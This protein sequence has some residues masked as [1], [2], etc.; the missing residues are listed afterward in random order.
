[1]MT[2]RLGMLLPDIPIELKSN[3]TAKLHSMR[4][5]KAQM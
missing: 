5:P 2:G 1:M 3:K 4:D